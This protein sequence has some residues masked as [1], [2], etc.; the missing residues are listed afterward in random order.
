[1]D[2]S[3]IYARRIV[4]VAQ[5]LLQNP[6]AGLICIPVLAIKYLLPVSLHTLEQRED[7]KRD[8][9]VGLGNFDYSQE[10]MKSNIRSR[11][12]R[13]KRMMT[14]AY[15]RRPTNPNIVKP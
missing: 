14:H 12:G 5:W 11:Y 3:K 15:L 7:R 2:H 13:T 8:L 6:N 4:V 9:E 10:N 1:M